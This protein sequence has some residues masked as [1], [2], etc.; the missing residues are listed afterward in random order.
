MTKDKKDKNIIIPDLGKDFS[1]EEC[2]E[3]RDKKEKEKKVDLS[4]YKLIITKDN[5]VLEKYTWG[6]MTKTVTG[7]KDDVEQIALDLLK[8]SLKDE[9]EFKQKIVD[10]LSVEPDLIV[11][12]KKGE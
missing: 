3:K 9:K 1:G 8:E 5:I 10:E 6:F 12:E 11:D 2:C 7:E 4:D